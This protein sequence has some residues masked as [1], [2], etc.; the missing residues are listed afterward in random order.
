MLELDSV[1]SFL[2]DLMDIEDPRE[3]W[4]KLYSATEILFLTLCAISCVANSWRN[5][6]L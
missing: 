3:D 4:N 6:E 5:I 2:D 1:D